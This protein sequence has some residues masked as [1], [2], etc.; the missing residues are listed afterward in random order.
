MVSSRS[1][2][3]ERG[4]GEGAVERERKQKGEKVS[5]VFFEQVGFIIMGTAR[6]YDR[7]MIFIG[8][9]ICYS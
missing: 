9:S 7:K 2:A 4:R 3:R 8:R 6:G 1:R 5:L